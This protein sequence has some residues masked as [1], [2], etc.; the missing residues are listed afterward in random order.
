MLPKAHLTLHFRISDS[1][2]VITP[3]WLSGSWR[4][5]CIVLCILATFSKC[6]LILL[7]SYCFCPLLCLSL[8][9]IFLWSVIF[10]RRSLVFPILLFSSLS[11]HWTSRKVFLTLPAILWNSAFRW[12]YHYFSPLLL[13]SL[14]FSAIFKAFSDNHFAFLH[15]FSLVMILINTSCTMSWTPVHISSRTLSDLILWIYLSLPLYNCIGFDLGHNWM[16]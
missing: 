7:G 13:P 10:L 3:S 1:R 14:L 12:V 5:F 11:L 15:F 4:S 2:W 9:E 8:H 16:V 6:L